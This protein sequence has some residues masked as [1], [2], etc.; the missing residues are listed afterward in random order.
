[1]LQLFRSLAII[2]QKSGDMMKIRQGNDFIYLWA[3]ERMGEIEDLTQA[4]DIKLQARV[5]N[6]TKDIAFDIVNNNIIRI[7]VTDE[8]A[9]DI[10]QYRLIIT[11]TL[12]DDSVADKD[13][14]CAID[15]VAFQIVST[16]DKADKVDEISYTSD[17]AIGLKGDKG[18]KGD[19]LTYA[20][21]TEENK[22]DLRAPIIRELGN[23]WEKN[24]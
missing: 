18:D 12:T 3:I 15:V 1:M 6:V 4:I 11:Y 13:R 10:G 16:S 9:H 2:G 24:W 14:K 20:D 5:L 19:A 21:L 17:I 23:N 22:D 8:W 7:E